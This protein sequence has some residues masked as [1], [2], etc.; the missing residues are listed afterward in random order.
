MHIQIDK[1]GNVPELVKLCKEEE[2]KEDKIKAVDVEGVPVLLVR[3][4]GKIIAAN[5]ICTHKTFDL[6]NGIYGDGFLTCPLHASTF[7]LETGEA[8]NPPAKDPL[9]LYEIVVQDGYVYIKI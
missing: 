6:A 8:L 1:G 2:V 9:E 4:N 7:E 5:R 3:I